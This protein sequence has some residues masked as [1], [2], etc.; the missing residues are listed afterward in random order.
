MFQVRDPHPEVFSAFRSK[1]I[2]GVCC[3]RDEKILRLLGFGL[4]IHKRKC[5]HFENGALIV[6]SVQTVET[7]SETPKKDRQSNAK[8]CS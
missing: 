7:T 8:I 2:V 4:L 5:F 1:P 3:I 6:N